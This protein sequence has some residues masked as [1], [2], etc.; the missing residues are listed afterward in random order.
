M[1]D[2][3]SSVIGQFATNQLAVSQV[4]DWSTRWNVWRKLGQNNCSKCDIYKF[5]LGESTSLQIVQSTSYPVCELTD[6]EVVRGELSIKC[7]IL[8][9][10]Q[11]ISW[12]VEEDFS[13][14][15][16]HFPSSC[17][18]SNVFVS[19]FWV[20]SLVE[21]LRCPTSRLAVYRTCVFFCTVGLLF[22]ILVGDD[23][24]Q[25]DWRW[26][27]RFWYGPHFVDVRRPSWWSG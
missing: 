16:L 25:Y 23:I 21:M 13:S 5:A 8:S 14:S 12:A 26:R 7:L 24:E 18:I 27:R 20:M 11:S 2:I 4:A 6:H 9:K 17:G 1:H 22:V 3:A 10:L 15:P 19:W